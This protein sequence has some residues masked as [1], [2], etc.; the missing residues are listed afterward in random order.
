[1]GLELVSLGALLVQFAGAL[2]WI[3]RTWSDA[4]Y[5]SWGFLALL[6]LVPAL[7]RPPPRRES[8][9]RAYL[10]GLCAVC[11]LDLLLAGLRVHLLSA[12]CAVV[13]LHLWAVSFRAYPGR[14]WAQRQLWLGLLVLPGAF[15]ANLLFGF[16]L[17]QL[18]TRLA[19]AG[20]GLYGLPVTVH[21]TVLELPQATIAVDA[22]CSGV[23][24]LYSGLLFG[25]LAA[26]H[27]PPPTVV[28][29]RAASHTKRALFW[30]ALLGGLLLA[31]AG[32][33]MCLALAQLQLHRPLGDSAHQAVGLLSFALVAAVSLLVLGHAP[34]PAAPAEGCP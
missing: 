33:V 34:R 5:E 23:K 17:Q 6:L 11:L 24:L 7:L 31:N 14:W 13:A 25:L 1:L 19:A 3:G 2:R 16:Q 22:T 27:R 10:A 8:P 18:A 20:L 26:D 9:S 15:W 32:R 28:G 12:L 21:G 4:T 29:A 30:V